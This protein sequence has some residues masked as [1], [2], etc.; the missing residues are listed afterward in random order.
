MTH[1]DHKTVL[2]CQDDGSR[3]A[4]IPTIA[5]CYAVMTSRNAAS[6]EL[7][8]VFALIAE[9]FRQKGQPW[10]ADTTEIISG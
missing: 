2:N 1:E 4:E 10:P 8:K 9:E 5:G 3:V 6:A 7:A